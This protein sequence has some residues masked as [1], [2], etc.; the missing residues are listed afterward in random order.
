MEPIKH[1]SE[2]AK[3]QDRISLY[4]EF[5]TLKNLNKLNFKF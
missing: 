2:T 1:Y 4:V 5:K 3:I